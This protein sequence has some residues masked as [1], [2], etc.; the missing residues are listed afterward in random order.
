MSSIHVL[1]PNPT[2]LFVD[3]RSLPRETEV[4][5]PLYIYPADVFTNVDYNN[6]ITLASAHHKIPITVVLNPGSG[7]GSVVDGNY[8]VAIRRLQGA[9]VNVLG[10]VHTTGATIPLQDVKDD[11][12]TW[13][14]LYPAIDGLFVDEMSNDDSAAHRAYFA[15]LTQ[16]AHSRRLYPVIGNPG[17][18]LVNTYWT[19]DCADVIVVYESPDWPVEATIKG[20]FDGGLIDIDFRRKAGLAY[21]VATVGSEASIT[22]MKKYLGMIYVTDDPGPNPWD[23]ISTELAD[24]LDFLDGV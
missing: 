2:N 13:L 22:M 11:V 21:D 23:T 20:D 5:I 19:Q 10:Y 1:P 4:L 6:I 15:Q 16:Y 12:D 9:G 24:L 18:L 17:T 3:A 7:P 8:T 14:T